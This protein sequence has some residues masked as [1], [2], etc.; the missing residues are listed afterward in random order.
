MS[1]D[2]WYTF[3][4]NHAP[5]SQYFK[6]STLILFMALLAGQAEINFLAIDICN[7]VDDAAMRAEGE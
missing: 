6:K 7:E 1:C 3:D 5:S 2:K 4:L